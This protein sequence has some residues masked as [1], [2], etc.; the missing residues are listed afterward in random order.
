MECIQTAEFMHVYNAIIV[1]KEIL[2]VF[3]VAIHDPGAGASLDKALDK[4][5]E[6]E[7]RGDLRI[8][9]RA[10]QASLQKQWCPSGCNGHRW[11]SAPQYRNT[12]QAGGWN[13]LYPCL[14]RQGPG[15]QQQRRKTHRKIHPA[16]VW[17]RDHPCAST[18]LPPAR[19]LM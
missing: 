16:P 8:L 5:I 12:R 10:Y 14:W 1:L 7:D 19:K 4:L 11:A 15:L 13:H 3:P 17:R 6:K 9:S 18:G 2:D